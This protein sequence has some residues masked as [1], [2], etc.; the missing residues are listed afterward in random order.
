[1]RPLEPL[2]AAVEGATAGTEE[3]AEQGARLRMLLADIAD[4]PERQRAALVMRE[5]SGL[6]FGE[7]AAALGTSPGAVRQALYEARRGLGQM[8]LGRDMDCDA[9][10]RQISNA[11]GRP[12]RR[13][14]RA[15]LRDCAHCRRF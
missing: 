9:A 4:L 3:R 10:M 2:G 8:E 11:E 5:L 1:E 6:G 7:I 15:H 13:G 12:R 14:V